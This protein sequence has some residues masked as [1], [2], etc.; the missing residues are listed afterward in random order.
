MVSSWFARRFEIDM[1]T[2]EFKLGRV[3][4]NSLYSP[5]VQSFNYKRPVKAVALEPEF[6]KKSTRH[7]VSGGMAELLNMSGKGLSSHIAGIVKIC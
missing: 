1:D 3:V 5:D 2:F 7:F 6:S 4:I